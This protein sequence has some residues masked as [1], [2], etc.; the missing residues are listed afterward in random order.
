MKTKVILIISTVIITLVTMTFALFTLPADQARQTLDILKSFVDDFRHDGFA[1]QPAR[2]G[3]KIEDDDDGE[4]HVF[5]AGAKDGSGSYQ[6]E[7]RRG[8]PQEPCAFYTLDLQTLRKIDAGEINA[9]TALG[10]ARAEDRTPMDIGFMPGFDP[11]PDFYA[12]FIPLTFHFW[13]RGFPE[14]VEFGRR[15]SREIHGADTVI[16]YY[17]NGFRSGWGSIGKGQHV[18]SDPRDQ[19]NPFPTMFI[20]I[21]GKA[22]VRIGGREA[23]LRSGQMILVPS[24]VSHEAWNPYDAPAEIILLMFGEGA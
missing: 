24:G 17:Q 1:A 9:S 20:C 3:I 10:R 23:V 11:G 15:Y 13:T 19:V 5:I 4:W 16:F 18:N 21:T 22:M 14:I 12:G 7:L 2:F 6:V 8:L